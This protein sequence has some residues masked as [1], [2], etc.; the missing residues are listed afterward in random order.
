[1][2][3]TIAFRPA[4]WPFAEAFFEAVETLKVSDSELARL[5]IEKGLKEATAELAA[6]RRAQA[7]ALAELNKKGKT[8]PFDWPLTSLA[9]N[10]LTAAY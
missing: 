8:G 6:R 7:K 1:M 3:T 9:S 10:A 5:C 4:N 2:K